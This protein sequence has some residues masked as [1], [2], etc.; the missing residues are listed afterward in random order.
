MTALSTQI[1]KGL[2]VAQSPSAS[3]ASKPDDKRSMP[4]KAMDKLGLVRD[5][6]LALHLPLR[7]EDET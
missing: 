6:D 7:Y 2:H 1:T 4:Q 5:I 3:K